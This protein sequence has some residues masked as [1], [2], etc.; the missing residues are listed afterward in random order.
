MTG[1]ECF[2]PL[3]KQLPQTSTPWNFARME[4]QPTVRPTFAEAFRFWLKLGFISFGGPT[5]QI[6]IMHTE[7]VDRK[8][9][10]DEARFL[11]AL[12]FCMLLP[13][14]EAQQ[15]ATYIGWLLHGTRGGLVAG[16]L[17][18]LPSA[19]ILWALSYIYMTHGT[20][21]WIGAVFAGLQPAVMALVAFAVLRIGKKALKK[22]LLWAVAALAFAAIFFLHAPFPLIIAAAALVGFIARKHI[23]ATAKHGDAKDL[24]THEAAPVGAGHALRIVRILGIGL[25][26]WWTPVFLAALAHHDTLRDMGL[27][28]SKA[29]MVTFGGA[30]AVLPYVAQQAV[31]NF[32]WLSP[33]QMMTGLGLAESTPG[34][35]IMVLQY[36]GFVGAWQHPGTLAPLAAAT[37]GAAITTWVTFVPCFIYIFLGAPYVERLRNVPALHAALTAITAAVVGVVLNLAVWF[38]WHV[39]KPDTG[40]TNWFALALAAVFFTGLWRWKWNTMLVVTAGAALGLA[41]HF[42]Q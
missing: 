16:I 8:K 12:N 40:G 35:L 3:E 20:V 27:F 6:A 42:F 7:L 14:P 31:E 23:P 13:G 19:F 15:L 22:P 10:I 1:K 11:H 36:V 38:G 30:Y 25:V 2:Q 37:L 9:W 18:V 32:A 26:L 34:P 17:F 39:I 24:A 29:A 33:E 28:F 41:R 21:P 5:G 4:N